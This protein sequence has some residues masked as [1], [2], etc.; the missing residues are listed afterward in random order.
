MATLYVEDTL[1]HKHPTLYARVN[2][3]VTRSSS[4]STKV[5]V[6]GSVY[7]RTGY[8]APSPNFYGTPYFTGDNRGLS[9]VVATSEQ[10]SGRL[11]SFFGLSQNNGDN[12]YKDGN[13]IYIDQDV[14]FTYGTLTIYVDCRFMSNGTCDQGYDNVSVGSLDI[15]AVP[16]NPWSDPTNLKNVTVSTNNIKP[17][18]SFTVSWTAATGGT[19]NH[20]S[21]YKVEF[22]SSRIGSWTSAGEPTSTSKSVKPIDYVAKNKVRVSDTIKCRVSAYMVSDV[23]GHSSGWLSAVSGPDVSVYKDGIIQYKTNNSNT[24]EV[25][26]GYYKDSGGNTKKMRYAK[27]K[28]SGGATKIIDVYTEH[29]E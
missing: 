21:K 18:G 26:K 25:T 28:T 17:D 27:Y 24:V 12:N 13:R 2:L 3:S 14:T 16:Y 6:K 20:I 29:Y 1:F 11:G 7:F 10:S 23:S 15:S 9:V 19:G 8:Y 4:T 22:Y 5:N